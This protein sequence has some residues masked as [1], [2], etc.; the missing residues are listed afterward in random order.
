MKR[1]Q[2][3][4]SCQTRLTRLLCMPSTKLTQFNLMLTRIGPNL[5]KK[6]SSKVLRVWRR[7][8]RKF[9]SLFQN[10]QKHGECFFIKELHLLKKMN[11][12]YVV[13][14]WVIE[15][16]FGFGENF[17]YFLSFLLFLDIIFSIEFWKAFAT[18]CFGNGFWRCLVKILF[19]IIK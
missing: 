2:C 3:W 14:W 19:Y 17:N 18:F 10:A 4:S 15:F 5:K 7:G 6:P 8:T 11:I 16:E 1:N 9:T 12:M 13:G